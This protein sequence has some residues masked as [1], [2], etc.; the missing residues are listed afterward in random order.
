MRTHPPHMVQPQ[1][2]NSLAANSIIHILEGKGITPFY[3]Y[4]N[5]RTMATVRNATDIFGQ[6]EQRY[7]DN[8]KAR[9]HLCRTDIQLTPKKD[10]ESGVLEPKNCF[11]VIFVVE[12]TSLHFL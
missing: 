6:R 9:A 3:F 11:N 7:C 4:V 8:K 2:N 5:Y 10:V 1:G 12:L